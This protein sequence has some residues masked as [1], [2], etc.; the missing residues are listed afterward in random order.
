MVAACDLDQLTIYDRQSVQKMQNIQTDGRTLIQ[1][2]ILVTD[3]ILCAK[4]NAI[5]T[6]YVVR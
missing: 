2:A 3:S 4:Q 1:S 6:D 5:V